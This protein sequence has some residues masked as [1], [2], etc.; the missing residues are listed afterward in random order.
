MKGVVLGL[1]LLL[2]PSFAQA[3][4]PSIDQTIVFIRC[5]TAA[6]DTDGTGVLVSADGHVLTA[7]HVAPEGAD[8]RGSIGTADPG[9]L[10]RMVID[11]A[12]ST[13]DARLLR[14][15]AP[16]DFQFVGVCKLERG[17]V[18]KPIIAAGF[19]GNTRTGAISFRQ[20]VLSTTIA[21]DRGV[22]ESD[23]QTIGGMSGGPVFSKNLAGIVGIVVG[24]EYNNV[25]EPSFGILSAGQI[26]RDFDL[27]PSTRPCFS[28]E[29]TIE[30][31]F[32][33]SFDVVFHQ[34]DRQIGV[35][36]D[37]AL[38]AISAVFGNFNN[39]ADR[40]ELIV[41][42]EGTYVFRGENISGGKLGAN[43]HCVRLE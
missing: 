3:Q 12:R 43:V 4:A 14:F 16:A 1:C 34:P 7:A 22:I 21:D 6:G 5:T 17:M 23:A 36:A 29:P 2:A 40:V 11:A 31:P 35:T 25:G 8:C 39:D 42:A 19:P 33:A 15:S 10:R 30:L 41:D 18:R 28:A 37:Q 13:V 9:A 26:A 20:G 32:K 38:C 27:Q 24:A